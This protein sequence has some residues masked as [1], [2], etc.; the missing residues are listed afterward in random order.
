M[1]VYFSHQ[2]VV[3]FMILVQGYVGF[4]LHRS[5]NDS[6]ITVI[7]LNYIVFNVIVS[8]ELKTKLN[9]CFGIVDYKPNKWNTSIAGHTIALRMPRTPIQKPV[10]VNK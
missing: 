9:V 10:A 5:N 7:F 4:F 1:N 3:Q 8:N 6:V 2:L